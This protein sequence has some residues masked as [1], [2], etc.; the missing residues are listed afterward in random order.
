MV[1][2][3]GGYE[4]RIVRKH[5]L[6]FLLAFWQRCR[7]LRDGLDSCI[8]FHSA[9][10]YVDECITNERFWNESILHV[11]MLLLMTFLMTQSYSNTVLAGAMYVDCLCDNDV[12]GADVYRRRRTARTYFPI[13]PSRTAFRVLTDPRAKTAPQQR[14]RK[15][16]RI[17]TAR[18]VVPPRCRP[19]FGRSTHAVEQ[20]GNPTIPAGH[21]L[22]LCS[23]PWTSL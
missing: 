2:G 19:Q 15:P 13:W 3:V 6:A 1:I 23:T 10:V 21:S 5:M 16:H 8:P 18:H 11:T 22:V 20:R 12:F 7:F 17:S 9:L 4:E 14:T